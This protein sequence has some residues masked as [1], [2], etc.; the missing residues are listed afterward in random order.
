MDKH[1]TLNT[2][3]VYRKPSLTRYGKLTEL[4]RGGGGVKKDGAKKTKAGGQA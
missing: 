3:K 2:K 1:S 4:T